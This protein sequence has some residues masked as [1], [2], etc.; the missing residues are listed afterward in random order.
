MLARAAIHLA[1]AAGEHAAALERA[2]AYIAAA[3]GVAGLRRRYGR[4]KTFAVPILANCALAGL[5]EWREVA[6]LPFELACFP[7]WA[8]R[9]LRLPVVSYAIPALVAIGQARYLERPPLNPILRMM[10][11]RAIEPSLAVLERMQPASGGYLEA[12]PLTSFV[13]MS[14]AGTG[15]AAHPVVRRAVEFLVN[16]VRADGSWPID[17]NLATWGTT[18]AVD[19]LGA[20]GED[21]YE[22]G[23]LDWLLGCQH[24]EEHPFTGAAPGGWAWTDLS[25]GV[26][27]ADDTPGALLALAAFAAIGAGGAT[28]RD[29]AGGQRA[30]CGGSWACRTGTAAGRRSAAAGG[31]C[32]STAAAWT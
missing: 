18:L 19:A 22:Q 11:R 30:A 25:G 31:G 12:T 15:R 4:D 26:P 1:G 16:S 2:E 3:G 32:R 27:D 24:L 20:A 6:A 21:H 8:L 9:F 28:C 13:V 17:T 23:C 14:L 29:R 5:V 10:R 7:Q